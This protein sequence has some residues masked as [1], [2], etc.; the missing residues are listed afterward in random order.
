MSSY[1][2]ETSYRIEHTGYYAAEALMSDALTQS[3]TIATT[4]EAVDIVDDGRRNTRMV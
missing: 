2:T 3:I 4:P 1:G